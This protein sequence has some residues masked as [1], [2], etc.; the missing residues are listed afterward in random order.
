MKTAFRVLSNSL[1]IMAI[2]GIFLVACTTAVSGSE[3]LATTPESR[4]EDNWPHWRGPSGNGAAPD[5]AN[6]PL[7]WDAK[8]NVKWVAELP[9][10]GSTTPIVWGNQI[11][12]L[13]AEETTRPATIPPVKRADSKTEPPGVFYRFVVTS[14]DRSTGSIVWQNVA[15]EQV[16]HEGKHPTHTYA[17]G[18]PTTDGERLY[19]S[20]GSR[21]IFAYTLKGELVWQKDL[22]DMNTRFGWGEA[23][24]PVLAGET[25][26]VN[27]D[28]EEN[29]FIVAL[30]T[31]TGEERWRKARDGEAT[32]WN[33]PLIAQVGEKTLA[34]V[35]GSGKA[36]AYDVANG[37]VLWESGGQTINAIP[38]PVQFGDFVVCMS[39]Y[40]GAASY[41][42]P[43]NST[44][45]LT[46]SNRFVWTYHTGTPYVP[47][48][49]VSGN[50]LFFT[51]GNNDILTV[52]NLETGKPIIE[53]QRLGIGNTYASPLAAG[54]KVYF[55]GREG[56][57]V[58]ISG[59]AKAE[60]LAKN[61][62][63]DT[64][65]A[66]PVVVGN[67][68]LLRSWSKLYSIQEADEPPAPGR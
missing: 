17:A 26:I 45:D 12:L 35:N 51:G 8:N 56:T 53:K 64:F 36:R 19:A 52:L 46:G 40:K 41:A 43:L 37:D 66:S 60:I 18:S 1:I 61:V 14:L 54:G 28:Q 5:T 33:T 27:W 55:V 47:S 15:T 63:S 31:R 68:L 22:G 7:T 25:L 6:P 30:D 23:V 44:G 21:G 24:T 48:P 49:T 59:D 32:S 50:R 42:I 4:P 29:S 65:D 11:Y 10:T 13:S 62:I 2:Q 9:G 67:Q 16:P 3:P 34:V 58:V 57:T 39:G 20:F 38:S